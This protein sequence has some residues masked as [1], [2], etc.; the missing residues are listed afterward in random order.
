MVVA[1][2]NFFEF[3]VVA[4]SGAGQIGFLAGLGIGGGLAAMSEVSCKT[5]GQ[6]IGLVIRNE[7]THRCG[8]SFG[9]RIDVP[10]S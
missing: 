2:K 7:N 8:C 9:R 10:L 3:G 1:G 6:R 5:L 4:D